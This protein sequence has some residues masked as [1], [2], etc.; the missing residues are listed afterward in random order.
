MFPLCSEVCCMCYFLLQSLTSV[1]CRTYMSES[2]MLC[3]HRGP[4]HRM[5]SYSNTCR[6]WFVRL[7]NTIYN[8]NITVVDCEVESEAHSFNLLINCST[9]RVVQRVNVMTLLATI[10]VRHILS[11]FSL[12]PTTDIYLFQ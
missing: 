1:G 8:I 11:L 10:D 5:T 4:S 6:L 9:M 12:S 7:Y 2:T 3:C